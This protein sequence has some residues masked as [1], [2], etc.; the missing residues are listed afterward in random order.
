MNNTRSIRLSS[1]LDSLVITL[2][3]SLHRVKQTIDNADRVGSKNFSIGRCP[4]DRPV[5][6]V[7]K[8]DV[9]VRNIFGL[10]KLSKITT[11]FPYN[12]FRVSFDQNIL[13][14]HIP[15]V[16]TVAHKWPVFKHFYLTRPRSLL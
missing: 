4:L 6:S 11:E 14:I 7:T 10:K 8:V 9:G 5:V 1:Y 12:F 3:D 16:K 15:Q 13:R 2:L